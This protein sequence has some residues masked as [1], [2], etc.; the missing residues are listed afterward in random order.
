MKFTTKDRKNDN[1]GSTNCA[2]ATKGGWWYNACYN[3]AL[4]HDGEPKLYQRN[5]GTELYYDYTELRVR[6][7]S[8][9]VT[10]PPKCTE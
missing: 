5:T 6:A 8:C 3:T 2:V 10:A 1:Y 7:K 9:S 4:T